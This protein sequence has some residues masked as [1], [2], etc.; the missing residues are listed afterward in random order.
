MCPS[1]SSCSRTEGRFTARVIDFVRDLDWSDVPVAISSRVTSLL[2]DFAAVSLAGRVT[3]TAQI[4]ADYAVAQHAGE[5]ATVLLDGRRA[6]APGA[7][8]ANGV[9]A[10][11]LDFDDGHRLV[12]GHPGANVVPAALAAAEDVGASREDLLAAIVVGYEIA[13]R[14]G[15]DLHARSSEYHASG[16]WGALG[17]AA[18]AARL[19]GL[20]ELQTRHSLGLAEYHAP[21]APILRSVGD[22]AMTK[23]ACGW[24][25][26][27]GVSSALLARDG[28]TAT[29]SELVGKGTDLGQRW[30][31]G[32]VYVKEFPCCRWSHPAIAASLALGAGAQGEIVRAS[33]RT[34]A[35][36]AAIARCPPATTEEAQYSLVWPVAVALAHGG[37][38]VDDVL[39]PG[40]SDPASVELVS[41]IE[42]EVDPALSSEFPARRL[43]SVV[44][45]TSD[46]GSYSSEPTEPPGEA[47]DP[48]W[49]EIVAAKFERFAADRDGEL[50]DALV[51]AYDAGG[52]S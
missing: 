13:I 42:V 2:R 1:T 21:I 25:A 36:A 28:F 9:L 40:L 12:K 41:R 37:F 34:F 48:R 14:A 15:I 26:F 38:S 35:E 16:A 50:P 27:I 8:F 32:E 29:A 44:V 46:G 7:A 11:A 24:G 18:A 23:D 33:V 49:A 17:A 51:A 4:A 47:D 6:S 19:L 52:A 30:C 10:N 43:A 5:S 22:P 3:P 45:E 31:V 39:E 20:D